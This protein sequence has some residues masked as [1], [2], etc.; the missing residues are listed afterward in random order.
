MFFDL[1]LCFQHCTQGLSLSAHQAVA[2]AIM[3]IGTVMMETKT[4]RNRYLKE[5]TGSGKRLDMMTKGERSSLGPRCL[6]EG[7]HFGGGKR[8]S[9]EVQEEVKWSREKVPRDGFLEEVTFRLRSARLVGSDWWRRGCG[10][11]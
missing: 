8:M 4:K 10:M 2:L 5:L 7:W 1:P 11:Q 6:G 9:E 3:G